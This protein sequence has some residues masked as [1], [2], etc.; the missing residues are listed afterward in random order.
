MRPLFALIIA[1]ILLSACDSRQEKASSPPAELSQALV[2][3]SPAERGGDPAP[4]APALPSAP[5]VAEKRAEK[6]ADRPHSV[7]SGRGTKAGS[8]AISLPSP[9]S[10]REAALLR[11]SAEPAVFELPTEALPL[12]REQKKER[13]ALVLFSFD[14]FLKPIPGELKER[15]LALA[16]SGS[17]QEIDMRGS[18]NRPDPVILPTQVLSAALEAGYFSRIY[19]VF[20][21]KVNPSQLNLPTFRKQMTESGYLT[22]K[23]AEALTLENGV[24]RGTVR[25]IPFSTAH[26]QRLDA[27]KGPMVVHID[28]SFFKGLYDN[29]VKTPLY[30]LLHETAVSLRETG[31]QPLAVSL[32]YSVRDGAISIDTRFLLRHLADIFRRPAILDEE[33]PETWKRRAEALYAA[34]M[35]SDNKKIELYSA[36]A[37][38]APKDPAVVY[39][40]F[41]GHFL[42]K[43][44]DPA[45]EALDRAVAL[46][47]GYAAAWLDLA[48]MAVKDGKPEIA[49]KLLGKA[50]SVYP[51]DPFIQMQR[52]DLL[53][54][55]DRKQEALPIIERLKT[56][57]WSKTY[58]SE[59][60]PLIERMENY[61]RGQKVA[62]ETKKKA[63]P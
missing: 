21:S 36:N 20:P 29:E 39:D 57:S 7:S 47:P 45:L 59:I 49:L 40:L 33:M 37:A 43:K 19:W 55:A 50:A 27:V 14:P 13:P 28:L 22:K 62:G 51:A 3:V 35:Y 54:Q 53:L 34:D 23:E 30:D 12:W 44:I 32:S 58:H 46:D 48:Q 4:S 1:A 60:P 6:S 10:A 56:L 5:P 25:G 42:A 18:L 38:K 24:Y 2:P 15:A 17:R 9:T 41:Q 31:W 63:H 8:A 52:A 11:Q 16:R 26:W 61:A